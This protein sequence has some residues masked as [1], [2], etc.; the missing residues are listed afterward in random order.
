MNRL[1]AIC[2]LPEQFRVVA[3]QLDGIFDTVFVPSEQI[4]HAELPSQFSVI[5]MDFKDI[6]RI[7]ALKQWLKSRPSEAKLI[8]VTERGSRLQV[9]QACALGATHIVHSM[10][11]VG[12]ALLGNWNEFKL[13]AGAMPAFE[14]E[15]QQ[16][17]AATLDALE[18][19][20]AAAITGGSPDQ[21]VMD[22]ASDTVIEQ[23]Q[24]SNL[25]S[26]I[27]TV[28]QHHSQTY[29]HSLLVT[30]LATGFG[31]YLGLRHYDLKRLSSGSILHDIGKV[32]V[33]VEILEK[34]AALDEVEMDIMK[35]HPLLGGEALASMADVPAEMMDVVLHHHEYLDGSG[36]PHGLYGSQISDIVRVMTIVD[37]FGALIERR[38]YKP[39]LPSDAAYK[40][41]VDMGPKLDQ[42]LVREFRSVSREIVDAA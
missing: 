30:G 7:V 13:L 39:P 12:P 23:L 19:V 41:L 10:A 40:I 4:Q 27:E 36:Y 26:W 1:T 20:F 32:R 16:G 14:I 3:A 22:R 29:Q 5:C 35:K 11:D 25:L 6:A 31:R 8:I 17:V 28:R 24:N 18:N 34:P 9:A 37:I 33:P 42:A 2:D 15:A 38:S 21:A